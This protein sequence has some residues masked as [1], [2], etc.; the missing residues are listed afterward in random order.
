VGATEAFAQFT[1]APLIRGLGSPVDRRPAATPSTV[2]LEEGAVS[3]AG[4]LP[5]NG[6]YLNAI[7]RMR[8]KCL[9]GARCKAG[10]TGQDREENPDDGTCEKSHTATLAWRAG[11]SRE[12]FLAQ[13]VWEKQRFRN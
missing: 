3:I 1:M 12:G 10:C 9:P 8:R 7:H 5:V 13:L 2:G 6:V 4:A 11:M